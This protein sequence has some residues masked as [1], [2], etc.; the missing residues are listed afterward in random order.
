MDNT[1]YNT[2]SAYWDDILITGFLPIL[3]L[4]YLNLRIYLKVNSSSIFALVNW[5]KSPINI[6]LGILP[7][8]HLIYQI[9]KSRTFQRVNSRRSSIMPDTVCLPLV[10]IDGTSLINSNQLFTKKSIKRKSIRKSIR[11]NSGKSKEKRCSM[12]V[13]I[14][15]LFILTHS[16]RLAIK[17]YEV[18]LPNS[19]TSRNYDRCY[20]I[21]R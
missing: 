18:L 12:L 5:F 17:I 14:V 1:D 16:F 9:S 13:S 21:G 4:S 8:L 10:A 20:I 3:V 11:N 15:L 6:N 19:N 7:I 2:L